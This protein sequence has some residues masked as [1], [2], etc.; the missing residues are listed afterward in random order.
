[1]THYNR[2]AV[3]IGIGGAIGS[4][5]FAATARSAQNGTFD[6]VVYGATPSGIMAAY[7]AAREGASVDAG[8]LLVIIQ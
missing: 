2:R 5:A 4:A 7:A 3:L 1:M 8:T 6:V